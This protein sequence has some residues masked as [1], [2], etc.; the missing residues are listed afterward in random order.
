[1][2]H[3]GIFH[4]VC[5]LTCLVRELQREVKGFSEELL[6]WI[7]PGLMTLPRRLWRLRPPSGPQPANGTLLRRLMLKRVEEVAHFPAIILST[8]LCAVKVGNGLVVRLSRH[9][10]GHNQRVARKASS[11][12]LA[13]NLG[14]FFPAGASFSRARSLVAKSASR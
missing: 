5:S 14:T 3:F 9:S 1:M 8:G 4:Y 10:G 6:A 2:G 12:S 13:L 11:G 7:S